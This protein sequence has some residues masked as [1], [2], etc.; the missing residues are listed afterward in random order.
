MGKNLLSQRKLKII[1]GWFYSCL[2]YLGE[3]TSDTT[4]TGN[5]KSV[6]I[7]WYF[8]FIKTSVCVLFNLKRAE[9]SFAL[10]TLK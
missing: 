6:N 3:F 4:V 9:N 10:Y 7:F 2:L 8:F 1:P 5:S